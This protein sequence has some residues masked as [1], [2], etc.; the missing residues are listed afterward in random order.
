LSPFLF[1]LAMEVFS[2][3]MEEYAVKRADFK[4]HYRCSKMRLTQMCFVDD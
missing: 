3:Q 1:V 2:K 4:F